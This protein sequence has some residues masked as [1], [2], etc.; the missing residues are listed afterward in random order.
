MA[1]TA[2]HPSCPLYSNN[3]NLHRTQIAQV[4]QNAAKGWINCTLSVTLNPSATTTTISDSR[5]GLT[6]AII[7]AMA[8]TADGATAIKNGIW[9]SNIIS[10]VGATP[11]SATLNHSGNAASDQTITFVL[12]G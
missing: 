1:Q 4:A 2:Y 8:T 12:I 5:I 3:E 10:A 9:V 7:P 6:T 11:G